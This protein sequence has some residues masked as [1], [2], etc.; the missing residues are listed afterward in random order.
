MVGALKL[1]FANESVPHSQG[2]SP[3]PP[4]RPRCQAP[5]I[6]RAAPP[7]WALIWT[8]KK[9]L[10]KKKLN[11]Q[12]LDAPI[13][14]CLYRALAADVLP[15]NFFF[16]PFPGGAAGWNPRSRAAPRSLRGRGAEGEGCSERC[17]PLPEL[18]KVLFKAPSSAAESI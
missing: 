9:K 8:F 2:K 13:Q 4:A 6:A 7:L 10:K 17:A 5:A 3:V 18:N 1:Q 14:V 16:F 15:G 11:F 12:S